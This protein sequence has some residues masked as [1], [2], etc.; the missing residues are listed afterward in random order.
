MI[1]PPDDCC[2]ACLKLDFPSSLSSMPLIHSIDSSESCQFEF[3]ALANA[4][5]L[6]TVCLVEDCNEVLLAL[7][8]ALHGAAI[9]E[10]PTMVQFDPMHCLTMEDHF[11]LARQP[12]PI[13]H[14]HR[15]LQEHGLVAD[16]DDGPFLHLITWFLDGHHHLE[17]FQSRQIRLDRWFLHWLED[18][19]AL[20]ADLADPE[21]D[22]NLYLVRPM[23]PAA[24]QVNVIVTQHDPAARHAV[25]QCGIFDERPPRVW[26]SA[27]YYPRAVR[28]ADVIDLFALGARCAF[29]DCFFQSG[30]TLLQ[31]DRPTLAPTY[32]GLCMVGTIP[33]LISRGD[34]WED[35]TLMQTFTGDPLDQDS[36]RMTQL[37]P[38]WEQMIPDAPQVGQADDEYDTASDQ[39]DDDAAEDENVDLDDLLQ[40]DEDEL[41]APTTHLYRIT[42]RH[43]EIRFTSDDPDA[44]LIECADAWNLDAHTIRALH[45]IVSSDLGESSYITELVADRPVD[46]PDRL[47]LVDVLFHYADPQGPV[48]RDRRV[49]ILP[50]FLNHFRLLWLNH[51]SH[52][53]M[54][55]D[56]R[57]LVYV[58]DHPWGSRHPEFWRLQHGDHVRILLPLSDRDADT[59]HLVWTRQ[60]CI[61]PSLCTDVEIGSC[62][63]GVPSNADDPD[64]A[65]SSALLQL[66]VEVSWRWPSMPEWLD[67]DCPVDGID[68]PDPQ[69]EPHTFADPSHSER[70][71][72]PLSITEQFRQQLLPFWQGRTPRAIEVSRAGELSLRVRTWY[73]DHA[74][75]DMHGRS[76][77]VWLPVV[78]STWIPNILEA[79]DDW[80]DHASPFHLMVVTPTPRPHAPNGE[81]AV[82]HVLL[83]QNQLPSRAAVVVS[84]LQPSLGLS[85]QISWSLP[86]PFS[87]QTLSDWLSLPDEAC[88]LHRAS[89]EIGNHREHPAS[90]G[91]RY[92]MTYDPQMMADAVDFMQRP[93]HPMPQA[94][95]D[96]DVEAAPFFAQFLHT[97][98]NRVATCVP[99]EDE[100]HAVVQTWFLDF[101]H[102]PVCR[103]PRA[104]RLNSD[105]ANWEQQLEHAWEDFLDRSEPIDLY[106]VLPTPPDLQPPSCAHIIVCQRAHVAK[107]AV[108][109]STYTRGGHV[110][111]QAGLV[112]AQAAEDDI[113][114]VAGLEMECV[115]GALRDLC[116]AFF[117]SIQFTPSTR[118]D[119]VNGM[120]FHLLVETEDIPSSSSAEV[121]DLD[122]DFH[123]S[124]P[125]L[126][127][128]QRQIKQTS[129]SHPS[130][131]SLESSLPSPTSTTIPCHDV[132][133]LQTQCTW[134]S[135]GPVCNLQNVV[136]WHPCTLELLH[137]MLEWSHEPPVRLD[138][139]T[140]GSASHGMPHAASAVVLL[141]QTL[142]GPR[143]GGFRVFTVDGGTAPRAEASAVL[144]ATWWCAQIAAV[145]SNRHSFQVGFH[146]DCLFAGYTA[147]GMWRSFAHNDIL[148]PARALTLWIQAML[149]IEVEW[150]HVAAHSGDAL[151]EAAD[152]V[153]WSV[154]H[155]WMPAPAIEPYINMISFDT[156]KPHVVEWLWFHHQAVRGCPGFP[157]ICNHHFV[158][159]LDL[160]FVK[161]P[162]A[163]D[164]PMMQRVQGTES[165]TQ[166][167][168]FEFSCVTANVLTLF[169]T[170]RG[171][172]NYVSSRQ[173]ALMRQF[174][175]AGIL[176]VGIQESRSYLEG[177]RSSGGYHILSAPATQRGTGGV[178]LWIRERWPMTGSEVQIQH[179]HLR[180][181][182]A[183][184]R[185]LVVSLNAHGVQMIIIV[186]HAPSSTDSEVG[187]D[188]WNGTTKAIPNK[189]KDWPIILL[190]DA[191]GRLGSVVS[192]HVG[193]H[194]SADENDAGQSLHSF[195]QCHRL[196]LPQTF[197]SCHRGDGMTW[198]HPNNATARLDYVGIPLAFD[199]MS[200]RTVVGEFD[201][202]LSRVDH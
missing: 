8:A 119:A 35:M 187:D 28:H 171:L 164:H 146:F 127:L 153:A 32:H 42:R 53:C 108:M 128:L 81:D 170:D 11:D 19:R 86:T 27:K 74:R 147:A 131:I 115:Y 178:Q 10:V 100:R 72:S 17:C 152:S 57:C 68:L 116:T 192:E 14:L 55:E 40:T 166:P 97:S 201:I 73:F 174:S 21:A 137:G 85:M 148:R 45:P 141:V 182:N 7:H 89:T 113:Q 4:M 126:D 25:L 120:H 98:W 31:R 66:P 188:F 194:Q 140:D 67:P 56:D 38:R 105:I 33:P 78:S 155:G 37:M 64:Q 96:E 190:T 54:L 63:D 181:W 121:E 168:D 13:Q 18:L 91:E 109:V 144:M 124:P 112:N 149:Q 160:P 29:R 79:W 102:H 51:V 200:T 111:R 52:H 83:C 39:I 6:S 61:H 87:R 76:R 12:R 186:A 107:R 47:I 157:Q 80:I 70:T 15:L 123:S 135:L 185:R 189:M 69:S 2:A 3:H 23:P 34:D 16:P 138:F 169:D 30:D 62:S 161:E 196:F 162:S 84:L 167:V 173:E 43:T 50:A 36:L 163:D 41:G 90:D 122:L 180:I 159:N 195:L 142:H 172:G 26:M 193:S 22:L 118:I 82:P 92:M 184:S 183:T 49:R 165:V 20:W 117:K 103:H 133:F 46:S 139:Y 129:G 199:A 176:C 177:H 158:L 143:F 5:R 191:N 136:K 93:S 65:D 197:E 132:E 60:K 94:I 156:C 1:A 130:V 106:E 58:N 59:V 198:I 48:K 125:H 9:S 88:R 145:Y 24:S 110:Y 114:R 104:V 179:T 150:C 134:T 44:M 151:N 154:V 95:P 99:G 71:G 175:D 101:L 77:D 75:P 202:S